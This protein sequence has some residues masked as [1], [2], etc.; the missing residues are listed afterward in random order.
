MKELNEEKD[1]R[2]V[3]VIEDN[4]DVSVELDNVETPVISI[5]SD[6]EEETSQPSSSHRHSKWPVAVV[7]VLLT[8]ALCMMAAFGYRYY[9]RY[10][11]IGVP[12]SVTSKENISKL[13]IPPVYEMPEVVKS[14]DSILGV[15]INMYQ[16]IGL[17][18][19]ITFTEPAVDDTDVYLYSRCCDQTSYDPET[20]RYLG[21]LVQNGKELQSDNSRLGYCAMANDNIVIGIARDEKVKDYCIEHKGSFFR[22]FILVSDGVLPGRFYLHGKVERRALA[23]MGKKLFYVESKGKETMWDFAD[24]LREYGFIDAI[25]IT[26]GTDYC[27]YRTAD[28]TA[29]D[30]GDKHKHPDGH[31]GKGIVPWVV[32]KKR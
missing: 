9:R 21:S 7:S 10:I 18:A 5:E 12:V 2:I 8:A 15:A 20:N 23:R 19:E 6:E 11:N 31:K 4:D 32:F 29:H 14:S 30:I 16:L 3:V 17:K 24:A 25:Y 22:Q 28:G 1:E 13:E 27:F 26:G